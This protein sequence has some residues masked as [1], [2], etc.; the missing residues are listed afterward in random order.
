MKKILIL[1][2]A[3]MM[4]LSIVA[5]SGGNSGSKAYVFSY[6]GED[7]KIDDKAQDVL[8]AIGTPLQSQELGTC[9]IGDKDKLFVYQ[10]F[11]VETYQMKGVDYFYRISLLTD[12]VSTKEGVSIGDNEAK[13]LDAYGDPDKRDTGVF[14]YEAKGMNLLIH[15]DA[16]STVKSIVYMR[17]E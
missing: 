5:C 7:L 9:G 12:Q 17:A 16:N 4:V 1:T 3:L 13:V 15:F 2:L 6:K 11:R 14:T 8:D 10:D